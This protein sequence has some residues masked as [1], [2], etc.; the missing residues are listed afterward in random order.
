MVAV[1]D[2]IPKSVSE[3]GLDLSRMM[4][5]QLDN[6]RGGVVCQSNCDLASSR[7]GDTHRIPAFEFAVYLG[8][9][10]RE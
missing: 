5:A 2:L 1:D 3:Q 4:P 9:A 10:C 7:G 8:D 6:V